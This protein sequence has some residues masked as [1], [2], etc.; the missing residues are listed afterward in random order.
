MKG[1]GET[2]PPQLLGWGTNIVLVAT[3]NVITV[4]FKKQDISQ[5]VLF[6]NFHLFFFG[7]NNHGISTTEKLKFWN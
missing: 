6:H 1:P 3:P 4:F 5:Q 2:G 7:S